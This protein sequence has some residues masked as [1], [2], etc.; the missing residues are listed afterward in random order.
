MCGVFCSELVAGNVDIV[1][2]SL[3]IDHLAELGELGFIQAE[4][5]VFVTGPGKLKLNLHD[6][7]QVGKRMVE[8]VRTLDVVGISVSRNVVVVVVVARFGGG[9]VIS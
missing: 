8:Q 1:L 4:I 5:H 2:E 9:S 6:L 7:P 3:Q